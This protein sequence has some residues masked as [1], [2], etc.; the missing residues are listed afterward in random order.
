LRELCDALVGLGYASGDVEGGIEVACLM[1]EKKRLLRLG[2]ALLEEGET[3]KGVGEVERLGFRMSAVD[4]Q[5][6]LVV[7]RRE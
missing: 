5:G 1:P 2:D 6:F 3:A 7:G 4:G